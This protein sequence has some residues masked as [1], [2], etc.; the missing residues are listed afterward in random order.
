V[1]LLAPLSA[2]S[3][4]SVPLTIKAEG[5]FFVGGDNKS[6]TEP[7]IGPIPTQSGDITINQMYVQYQIPMKGAQHVAIVMVHGCCLSSK[8][9]ETTPRR[10]HGL[11]RILRPQES[12][13]VPR[14]SGFARS[15]GI[16]PDSL[17]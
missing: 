12:I 7:G 6:V 5:S 3:Q 11:E 9:W 17:Q 14:G 8:T 1:A 16:R 4:K 15:L 13:C 2:N 10:A